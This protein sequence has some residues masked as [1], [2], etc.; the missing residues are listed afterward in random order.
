MNQHGFVRISCVSPRVT[1][2]DPDANG[3]EIVAVL[4]E[5]GGSD[6]VLY[7]ELSRHGLHLR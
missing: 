1:V 2:A 3:A 7:P 4:D 5:L 6:I